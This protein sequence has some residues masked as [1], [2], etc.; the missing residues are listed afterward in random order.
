[1]NIGFE[2]CEVALPSSTKPLTEP[3]QVLGSISESNF[4]QYMNNRSCTTETIFFYF[5]EHN[6][7]FNLNQL[8]CQHCFENTLKKSKSSGKLFCKNLK[9]THAIDYIVG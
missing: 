3:I 4:N 7:L 5:E 8:L 6:F 1:M 9:I 2:F